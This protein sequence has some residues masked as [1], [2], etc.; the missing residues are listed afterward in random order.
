MS[1]IRSPTSVCQE[2]AENAEFVALFTEDDG[3]K[4][5][6]VRVV[7]GDIPSGM[8]P[9]SSRTP[10]ERKQGWPDSSPADLPPAKHLR[11]R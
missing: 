4:V 7:F 3:K 5:E 8:P 2:G 6:C 10:A 11:R 9:P 1:R